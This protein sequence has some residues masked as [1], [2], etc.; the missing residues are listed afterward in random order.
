VF[1]SLSDNSDYHIFKIGVSSLQEDTV[2][3]RF[4]TLTA[5]GIRS[6]VFWDVMPY[7]S[8][9]DIQRYQ[10]FE[11]PSVSIFRVE[12]RCLEEIPQTKRRE[13]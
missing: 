4:K 7:S 9:T 5:V 2:F 8:L 3:L 1:N 12:A 11:A 6:M 10:S 13:K